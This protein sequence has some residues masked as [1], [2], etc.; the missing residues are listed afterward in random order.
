MTIIIP[1][2]YTTPMDFA[3]SWARVVRGEPPLPPT[4][5][6]W[7]REF[8]ELFPVYSPEME[9][10]DH[11]LHYLVSDLQ[12]SDARNHVQ[13]LGTRIARALTARFLLSV[14]RLN[15]VL[16]K[17][18]HITDI[19]CDMSVNTASL[20]WHRQAC[21]LVDTPMGQ[22]L[23]PNLEYTLNLRPARCRYSRNSRV[24][25]GST[26]NNGFFSDYGTDFALMLA[27]TALTARIEQ[28]NHSVAPLYDGPARHYADRVALLSR[29]CEV[30]TQVVVGAP[31]IYR[32]SA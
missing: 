20:H 15:A 4:R 22:R 12:E 10:T 5:D 9:N 23:S 25:V 1:Q 7:L 27:V 8:V 21:L 16:P 14:S 6:A 3:R 18:K 28:G 19:W 13:E 30:N 17:T 29:A 11:P 24:A 2:H 31:S 26:F 32:I